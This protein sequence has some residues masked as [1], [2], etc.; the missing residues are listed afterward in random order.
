MYIAIQPNR[1]YIV[2][3]FQWTVN[4]EQNML[5]YYVHDQKEEKDAIVIPDMGCSVSVERELMEAFISVN[6]DFAICLVSCYGA[7]FFLI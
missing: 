1:F 5:A 3:N 2:L 7:E 6:P 4:K